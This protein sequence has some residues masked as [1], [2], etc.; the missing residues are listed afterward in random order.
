MHS[1]KVASSRKR[2]FTSPHN[3][4]G[5]VLPPPLLYCP[6][7]SLSTFISLSAS[8]SS[9]TREFWCLAVCLSNPISCLACRWLRVVQWCKLRSARGING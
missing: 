9:G 5:S 7:L 8:S 2:L 1:S 3:K 4:R 6:L